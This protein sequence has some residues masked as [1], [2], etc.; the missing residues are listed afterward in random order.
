LATVSK[1]KLARYYLSAIEN[2]H[3]GEE[4]PEL[5]VNIDTDSVNLEHILPQKPEDNWPNFTEEDIITYGRRIGNLTLMNTK[6]NNDF[7]SSKFIDKKKKY[8]ESDLWITNSLDEHDKWTKEKIVQRQEELSELAVKTW[9][10][11]FD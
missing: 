4:N 5:L 6:E 10:L 1:H 3:R 9:S 7:K 2:F 11:K 8:K